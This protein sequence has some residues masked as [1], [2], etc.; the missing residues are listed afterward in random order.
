MGSKNRLRLYAIAASVV[1]VIAGAGYALQAYSNLKDRTSAS[2]WSRS[3]PEFVVASRLLYATSNAHSAIAQLSYPNVAQTYKCVHTDVVILSVVPSSL[4][5]SGSHNLSNVNQASNPY[6]VTLY[7]GVANSTGILKGYLSYE[8]YNITREWQSFL[9]NQS[10]ARTYTVSLTMY[11]TFQFETG[12][13]TLNVYQ[14]YDNIPYDPFNSSFLHP[15]PYLISNFNLNLYFDLSQAPRFVLPVP[16]NSSSAEPAS[17]G[18]GGGGGGCNS[19]NCHD[20][21][22]VVYTN[23]SKSWLPFAVGNLTNT[24]ENSEFIFGTATISGNLNLSFNSNSG[25]ALGTS[26]VGAILASQ[27]PSWQGQID[28]N[29]Y[30]GQFSVQPVPANENVSMIWIPVTLHTVRT[31]TMYFACDGSTCVYHGE[32]YSTSV[33]ISYVSSFTANT[34]FLV[35]LKNSPFWRDVLGAMGYSLIEQKTLTPGQDNIQVNM[36]AIATGYTS[37]ASAEQQAV[38]AASV[39]VAT[40][41]LALAIDTGTS[42]IPLAGTAADAVN[43]VNVALAAAGLSLAI[44][45]AFESIS[46]GVNARITTSVLQFTNVA[47][48][49]TAGT[50]LTANLYQS[51]TPTS[52]TTGSGTYSANMPQFF[53]NVVPS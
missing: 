26:V 45:S 49:G 39:F 46:Y 20:T 40:V 50:T 17:I 38:S 2:V 6:E 16:A 24:N 53:I 43:D 15:E 10:G 19:K 21:T 25:S 44:L 12:T 27:N 33:E 23:T 8:F 5:Q 48:A 42:E 32:S 30:G 14:Y 9:L 22:T 51:S 34:G 37:A 52:L 7:Q 47:N 36:S 28:T 35:N 1:V 3:G 31:K 13:S 4:S 18:G 41:G 29:A 11:A